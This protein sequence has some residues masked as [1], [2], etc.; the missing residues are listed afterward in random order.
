MWS[1]YGVKFKCPTCK[2]SFTILSRYLKNKDS[3]I[4]PCCDF[5]FP[6]EII[7]NIKLSLIHAS[8]AFVYYRNNKLDE[9][10]FDFLTNPEDN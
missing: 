5:S 8:K 7:D 6:S 2:Q 10:E 4:C 3:V 1:S 9:L